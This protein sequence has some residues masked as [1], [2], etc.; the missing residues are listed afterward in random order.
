VPIDESIEIHKQIGFIILVKTLLHTLAHLIHLYDE[1]K[2]KI[3]C[4]N[5]WTGLFTA[6]LSLGYPTGI[7][8]FVLLLIIIMFALPFVRNKGY[9]QVRQIILNKQ[10]DVHF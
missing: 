9:F 2:A 5:F 4:S 7:V 6:K 8:D 1:C 10:S 3:V